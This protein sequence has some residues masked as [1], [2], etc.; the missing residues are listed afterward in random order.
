MSLIGKLIGYAPKVWNYGTRLVKAS[1]YIIFEDAAHAGVKAANT[2]TR[3]TGQSWGSVL[4]NIIKEG[5]KGIEASVVA[6][7]ALN[8]GFLKSVWKS[9]KEVP[10]VLKVSAK[11][12]AGKAMVA[13]KAAG[14]TGIALKLAGLLG[15]AKGI[16]KGLGKKM[17]LIGNLMLV[18]FELPNIFK[19]TKEKGIIQG[20]KEVV[21]A[22]TR[23]TAASIASAIG[24]AVGGPIGGIIGFV[25]GDWL[26]SK[27]VGKSY[28]EHNA[29]EEQKVS[30]DMA[31]LQELIRQQG[32]MP[33]GQVPF[34]G[35]TNP[36]QQMNPYGYSGTGSYADDFMM[37]NTNFNVIV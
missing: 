16:F 7:K 26:A 23:L 19:A 14:K 24:T 25:A 27:V 4:K 18:A 11:W 10:S 8:G 29:E 9:I 31:R 36:F 6:S 21:K 3:S 2:V 12:S 17:P 15:G 35:G 13:A 34:T 30:E 20:G 28:T 22:G 5:G 32:M 1:P 33:Q 37:Q